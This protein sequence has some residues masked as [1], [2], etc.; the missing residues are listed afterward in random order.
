M[1]GAEDQFEK[2]GTNVVD[3]LGEDYD[4]SSIMHYGP[5]AFTGNG[6][7]TIVAL[8]VIF[9]FKILVIYLKCCK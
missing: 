9:L 2:Y 4:Y 6:R 5:Y 7:R 8:K 3:L 1:E